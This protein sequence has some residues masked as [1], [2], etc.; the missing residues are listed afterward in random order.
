MDA[1]PE[2]MAYALD[3]LG[4][5]GVSAPAHCHGHYLGTPGYEPW[6]RVAQCGRRHR[7]VRAARRYFRPLS[8][9]GVADGVDVNHATNRHGGSE[10]CQSIMLA[11]LLAINEW[12]RKV[13]AVAFDINQA[14][15][16]P[17]GT[18]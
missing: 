10:D 6:C 3:T 7:D 9:Q 12:I 14:P 15:I 11:E 18:G 8:I 1:A 17:I 13:D 5:D 16:G 4:L 2:E